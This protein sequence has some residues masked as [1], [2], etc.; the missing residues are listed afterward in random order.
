MEIAVA[1]GPL[2]GLSCGPDTRGENMVETGPRY[3]ATHALGEMVSPVE[4]CLEG[5]STFPAVLEIIA[6]P[7]WHFCWESRLIRGHQSSK[8]GPAGRVLPSVSG[9]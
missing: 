9:T 3:N 2:R 1:V 7:S 8:K 5:K 6:Q 4:D